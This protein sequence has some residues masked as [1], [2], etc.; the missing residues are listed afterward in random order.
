MK[1]N[2]DELFRNKMSKSKITAPT[3][4]WTIIETKLK[5]KRNIRLGYMFSILGAFSLI[6][7]ILFSTHTETLP[8]RPLQKNTSLKNEVILK[9]YKDLLIAYMQCCTECHKNDLK[10]KKYW[11]TK[12]DV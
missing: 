2:I 5:R 1:K 4:S 8:S 12:E 3:E 6:C 7:F 9:E 10:L 11:D